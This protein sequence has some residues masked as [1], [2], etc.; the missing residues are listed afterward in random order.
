MP[1]PISCLLNWLQGWGL[2]WLPCLCRAHGLSFVAEI[3]ALPHLRIWP[4][5]AMV[6]AR[7]LKYSST[8]CNIMYFNIKISKYQTY[9]W[10][11]NI[12]TVSYPNIVINIF[13]ISGTRGIR[14]SPDYTW[15]KVVQV[16]RARHDLTMY[17]HQICCSNGVL[18]WLKLDVY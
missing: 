16:V 4:I 17:R 13:N 12:I 11:H 3:E 15:R 1:R 7:Y 2:A 9:N 5:S 6:K 18:V 14:V 10:Y 8:S